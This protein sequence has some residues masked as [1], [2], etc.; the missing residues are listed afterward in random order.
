MDDNNMTPVIE[1]AKQ[2]VEVEKRLILL[3]HNTVAVLRSDGVV[4]SPDLQRAMDSRASEP[5]RRDRTVHVT[6]IDSFVRVV[7]RWKVT[8][9]ST[10]WAERASLTAVLDDHPEGPDGTAWGQHRVSFSPPH[11][12]EWT[13]WLSNNGKEMAQDDFAQWIDDN[14]PDVQAPP[15]KEGAPVYP[16]QVELL[17]MARNL[18]IYTRGTF[19]RK[20][21]PLTSGGTLVVKDEHESYT[22]KIHRA[23]PLALRV[24]EGGK[25]YLVEARMKFRVSG[26][27]AVFTYSLYRHE[28]IAR[29]A[30]EEVRATAAEKC[31][32]VPVFAGV[33]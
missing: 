7:N 16:T 1:V 33:P 13:K 4:H 15:A 10:I 28:E 8:G 12:P 18:S 2:S 6:D 17:E 30:F 27:R 26:A 23:F 5:R 32:G 29:K 24:F 25:H 22:T 20:I 14:A 31:E 9:Q 21:D 19:E 3:D 11:S